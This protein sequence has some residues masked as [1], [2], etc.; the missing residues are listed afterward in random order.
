MRAPISLVIPTLNAEPV[1]GV[2]LASLIEGISAG[3]IRELVVTDGGSSDETLFIARE[4][5]AEIIKGAA[6]RGGQLRRG[7]DAAKG[8]WLLFLHADTQ[9]SAGWSEIVQ[10]HVESHTGPASFQ[11]QF[12]TA[13][14]MA[15]FVAGWANFRT[16][17]F[18]LPYGDQALLIRREDYD[19]VGGYPDIPLMEDVALVR[20]LPQRVRILPAAAKTGASRYQAEGWLRRGARNLIVLTR[21]FLGADP[22]K[23][24][25]SYNRR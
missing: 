6:G 17:F 14:V 23:L 19:A 20:A 3:L 2:T 13:G 9:L 1:L 4:A 16:R 22:E 12:D 10:K 21:Y 11:L 5:G 15:R 24:S 18:G 25:R 8:E 7:A